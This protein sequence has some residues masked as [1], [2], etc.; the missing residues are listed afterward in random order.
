DAL[1]GRMMINYDAKMKEARL[2]IDQGM[3]TQ[4][5]LTLANVLEN[6]YTSV[7]TQ[8]LAALPPR[9]RQSL[10]RA[11]EEFIQRGKDRVAREKGFA[12]LPLGGKAKFFREQN[13]IRSAETVLDAKFPHFSAF[14][15]ELF[16]QIRN[17]L[18]HGSDA[19]V[20]EDE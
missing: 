7:Y 2:L 4:S 6:L 20:D 8:V 10:S 18:V 5:V 9:D 11:E 1:R 16:R 15:P 19:I 12:G 14:D 13:I 17:A 3:Y